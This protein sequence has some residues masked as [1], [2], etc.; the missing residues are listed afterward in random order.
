M[1]SPRHLT[2]KYSFRRYGI[3]QRG[4]VLLRR[5]RQEMKRCFPG[6]NERVIARCRGSVTA[7]PFRGM[8]Y[9][10]RAVGSAL[11]P[12]LLGTYEQELHPWLEEIA[13]AGYGLIHVVGAA[14]GYYAVGLAVRIPG[15]RVLAYDLDPS[16]PRLL[17]RLAARNGVGDQVRFREEF[18]AASLASQMDESTLILCDI[19]G[20][21]VDLLEPTHIP[22]LLYADI[23]VEVHD[24]GAGTIENVLRERFAATHRIRRIAA[25]PRSYHDV[26][27]PLPAFVTRRA[28][29]QA[30]DEG[31]KFGLTWLFMTRGPKPA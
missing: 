8:R 18:T 21:E 19:E 9:L 27:G 20:A 25:S 4:L 2:M 5:F 3:R 12:K 7:G 30:I 10:D 1:G 24:A 31:R 17:R 13:N 6:I 28:V 15:C 22:E 14:E 26:R 29:E 23:L 11:P 16:S